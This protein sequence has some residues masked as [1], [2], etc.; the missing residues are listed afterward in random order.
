M[1]HTAKQAENATRQGAIP[2]HPSYVLVAEAPK[3]GEEPTEEAA[4]LKRL[5]DVSEGEIISGFRFH[6]TAEGIA[7]AKQMGF[8]AT[9]GFSKMRLEWNAQ[10]NTVLMLHLEQAE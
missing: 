8:D 6:L 9:R 10:Q 3:V 1:I 7:K 4:V 2:F 5:S